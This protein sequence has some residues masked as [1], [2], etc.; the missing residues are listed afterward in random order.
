MDR[1]QDALGDL[2]ALRRAIE[3]SP[4]DAVVVASPENV[5]YAADVEI[6]TQRSIRDR[7]AVVVWAKGREPVFV[8][9]QVEE[10]YAR[11]QGWITDLRPYKEF[12]TAPMTLVVDVLRELGLE[13]G[14]VGIETEY[15][16]AKYASALTNAL[17]GLRVGACDGLF[18]RVRAFKT[19]REL[20]A[21]AEGFRATELAL[22]ATFAAT[23][24]GEDEHALVRRLVDE[25]MQTGAE[26]VAFSHI[27]AGPNTGFPHAAP[28]GYRVQQGDIVKADCGGM[29]KGYP[30]NI[31]RTAVIGTP[32][33]DDRQT[34]ARLRAIHHEVADMLRPGNTGRQLFERATALHAKHGI[35]FP[36]AHNGHSVG[37]EIHEHPIISPHD[38]TLYEPGMISTVE[39]RVRWVGV[40]GLHM[41]DLYLVTEGAPLLL[42]DAFDN[43]A[44]FEI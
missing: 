33:A 29:Y 25:I 15:L 7:L 16:A 23:R 18:R 27:N 42:T 37:L 41:E 34:W 28:T 22:K 17:P 11:Q 12:V 21:I 40:K 26:A 24:V 9:C 14:H 5:K 3:A 38:D 35:P 39:T 32:S 19:P 36:Y 6:S 43:E 10:G 44:I 30:S 2:G 1:K 4:F 13:R 8:L 20:E 31:G